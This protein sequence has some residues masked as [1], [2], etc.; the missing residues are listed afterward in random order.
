VPKPSSKKNSAPEIAG[1]LLP[2]GKRGKTCVWVTQ[3]RSI[4]IGGNKVSLLEEK[5][6]SWKEE[7]FIKKRGQ[8]FFH[9]T[10]KKGRPQASPPGLR[11][12][13]HWTATP[14]KKSYAYLGEKESA[15]AISNKGGKMPVNTFRW[16]EKKRSDDPSPRE[17]EG[18]RGATYSQSRHFR[19]PTDGV[20]KKNFST[21][22]KKKENQQHPRK[23]STM[24]RWSHHPNLKKQKKEGER[25]P[26]SFLGKKEK[27]PE[28]R[29]SVL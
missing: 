12:E 11:K 10:R 9:C 27:K 6:R 7:F 14:K 29:L 22:T 24:C 5:I 25:S 17:G 2:P 8:R 3:G 23:P 13:T 19:K 18:C 28:A 4:T 15:S 20:Q 26:P 1:T 16:R 21:R